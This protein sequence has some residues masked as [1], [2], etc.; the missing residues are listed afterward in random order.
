MF[1]NKGYVIHNIKS[2]PVHS[3]LLFIPIVVLSF[4]FFGGLVIDG[5]LQKGMDNMERRLG[6]DLM[7][8]PE[9]A[10]EDAQN[11]ILEGARGSFYFD[12]SVYEEVSLIEGV[13]EVTPQFFLKSL[14]ADCCSSEVE[15]VFFDP[16]TDFLI[17][18]WISKE[19][20]QELTNDMVVTG[21]SIDG[22]DDGVIKLFG[23]EYRIAAGMSKTGTSLDSS[24]YFTFD[25]F[26]TLISDAE[27]KGSFL[28][29]EQKK[30]NV[31]SSVFINIR[32]GYKTEDVL[33]E[34]HSAVKEKFEVVYPKQLAESLSLNLQGIYISTHI[35]II[36]GVVLSLI[37]LLILNVITANEK[38]REVALI[39]IMGVPKM[40]VISLLSLESLVIC[41]LGSMAGC[42]LGSLFVIP[43]GNYI[44]HLLDMPYLGP[45]FIDVLLLYMI[46]TA[47]VIIVGL[48]ASVYPVL[49]ISSIEPYT[50]LRREGE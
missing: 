35:I 17:E 21:N 45:D 3:V 33:K 22:E 34:I 9:G 49:Y 18:P 27:N 31:I 28:T 6:A 10:K 14:A 16:E 4:I 41:I 5:S 40:R 23:R 42:M 26:N 50:A 8:V 46:I 19:Y 48:M 20:K 2:N 30:A 15:I 25:A 44:G 12:K 29:D 43:F 1:K 11:M 47:I 37:I 36:T 7:L 32:D 38:K 13:E 24:V 39:R